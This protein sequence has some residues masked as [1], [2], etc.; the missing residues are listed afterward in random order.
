MGGGPVVKR[1]FGG[2]ICGGCRFFS[3]EHSTLKALTRAAPGFTGCGKT[4]T[5]FILSEAKNLFLF[6]F[7]YLNRREILRFAQNDRT[8]HFF[9]YL[10]SPGFGIH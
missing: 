5:S 4:Q 10:C 9:C 1:I 3:Q 2:A 8:R 7:V 6:L